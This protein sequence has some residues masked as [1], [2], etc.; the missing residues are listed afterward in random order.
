MCVLS[1]RF[2]LSI[3]CQVLR[4]VWLK[5]LG[6]FVASCVP[7]PGRWRWGVLG[8]SWLD[9]AIVAVMYCNDQLNY[10]CEKSA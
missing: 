2:D 8:S 9:I 1:V 4:N 10:T 6:E 3:W 7:L 5:Q